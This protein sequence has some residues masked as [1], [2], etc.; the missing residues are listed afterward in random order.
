MLAV[1]ALATALLFVAGIVISLHGA[2]RAP[3]GY[4]DSTGFHVG[5]STEV[6]R[7]A[8]GTKE[9]IAVNV[10]NSRF[11]RHRTRQVSVSRPS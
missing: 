11:A 10:S 6:T 7:S 9:R 8:P 4:E 3:E 1:V 2:L 5:D